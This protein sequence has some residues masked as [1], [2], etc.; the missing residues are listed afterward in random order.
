MKYLLFLS[1]AITLI[2]GS[3]IEHAY[4]GSTWKKAA[5]IGVIGIAAGAIIGSKLKQ[6]QGKSRASGGRGTH[7]LGSV[8]SVVA[9]QNAL[10]LSGFDAGTPDGQ[11]GR[12]TKEA[13]RQFPDI[14]RRTCNG[15]SLRFAAAIADGALNGS[16]LQA[17]R[18]WHQFG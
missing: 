10:N 9:I 8:G 14:N 1:L 5:V 15:Q 17:L 6:S 4:A 2:F 18:K 3:N 12:Q 16:V 13:I 11:M 7:G